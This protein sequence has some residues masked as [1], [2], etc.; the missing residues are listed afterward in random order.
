MTTPSDQDRPRRRNVPG[1]AA[2]VRLV[3]DAAGLVPYVRAL[4][5]EPIELSTS[6]AHV[7]SAVARRAETFLD[8]LERTVFAAPASPYRPLL[9]AAR[10]DLARVRSL[11][12]SDGVE[13]ALER[14]GRDGVY[15]TIDEFKARR[16][17]RRGA[18]TIRLTDR[19]FD[20]PL[21]KSGLA[22]ASGGTRSAG[23]WTTISVGNH[24]LGA[25]HL[26]LALD[27]YGLSERPLAVWLPYAHGASLWAVLALAASRNTPGRWFTQIAAGAGSRATYGRYLA[28]RAVAALY[29]VGLPRATHVPVGE[30][31][32]VLAWVDQHAP[33]AP[34]GVFTTPSSALRLALAAK[35]AGH[36]LSHVTFITIGEPLTPVKLAMIREVGA[37]AFSSLGF[38]EFGRATYGC[39]AVAEGDDGHLCLDEIAVIQRRRPVDRFGTEVD[40]LLFTSLSADARQILINTETGDGATLGPRA[41]GCPLEAL[42][43]TRQ[44]SGIRS[45]E[46]LNAEGHLFYG[47]QLITLVEETLPARFGGDPTDFQLLEEE[48]RDGFT[49]LSILVHPRLDRVDEAA[50]L[51]CVRDTLAALHP[52]NA[53]VWTETGTLRL[54]R[55]APRVTRSGKLMTL[56]REKTLA[57][58]APRG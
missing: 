49:R 28:T 5:A 4:L 37:R 47:S 8:T 29:G 42:G 38:T 11:V 22:A 24:R 52:T 55:D 57:S 20:N 44:L 51:G 33:R 7:R 19:A 2:V 27:A 50:V 14:L 31:S 43:W 3:R 34:C 56:H 40:A 36:R 13:G 53:R 17:L 54:R 18:V 9:E 46:K 26:A 39:A 6:I 23:L 58:S 48:D 1:A 41:C 30:E 32:T 21:V 25:R 35:R 45:F 16:E 12:G 10:Y 15:V